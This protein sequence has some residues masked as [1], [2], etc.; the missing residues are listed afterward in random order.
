MS[1]KKHFKGK[2][3]IVTGASSGIGKAISIEAAR[4]GADVA[5]AARNID[6][7]NNVAKVVEGFGVRCIAVQTDVSVKTDAENLI[8]K[9]LEKF[10]KIDILVNNAGISMRAMFEKLELSVFEKVMNINFMGTVYCTKYAID[11]ILKQKGTIVG[12]SSVSGFTPLPARTAYS[13]SKY[14]MYGF[15]TTLRIEN[16]KRGLHVLI[17]HP[18]F[19]ESDIRK[20]ALMA[21]GS[22]QGDTPRNEEKMM[23]SEEVAIKILKAIKKKKRVQILNLM[24]KA[25]WILNKFF[26]WWTHKQLYKGISKEA[27]TPLPKWK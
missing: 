24:G 21:D 15:L 5:I 8:N 10:N 11:H 1:E 16:I 6:K 20:H 9:T 7:L 12:V 17:T 4:Q 25:S 23:T 13:S 2:V 27:D 18:G 22:E 26:P 3:F 19:T 14:A